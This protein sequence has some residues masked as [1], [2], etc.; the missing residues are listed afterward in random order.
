M[1]TVTKHL[2]MTG[3]LGEGVQPTGQRSTG[4]AAA[5]EAIRR[6]ETGMASTST[7]TIVATQ[8]VKRCQ[9]KA[10]LP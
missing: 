4:Q 5:A 8:F 7:Q 3:I 6:R 2:R 10:L 9:T 1:P